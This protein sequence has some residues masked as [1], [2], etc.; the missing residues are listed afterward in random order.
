MD[1]L[2]QELIDQIVDCCYLADPNAVKPCGLV[3][4]RW[5]HRSRYHLFS[6]VYLTPENLHLFLDLVDTSCHPILSFIRELQLDYLDTPLNGLNLPRLFECSNLTHI[7]LGISP[8]SQTVSSHEMLQTHLRS[9]SRNSISISSFRLLLDGADEAVPLH[10]IT[11]I[12]ACLASVSSLQIGA[13][14]SISEETGARPADPPSHLAHL[15]LSVESGGHLVLSWLGSAPGPP[16]LRTL[17]FSGKVPSQDDA[18]LKE[19]DFQRVGRTLET[20]E[21]KIRGDWAGQCA[22][23]L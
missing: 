22:S 14:C 7:V 6:T 15:N 18:K 9:W 3:C 12:I 20:L 23:N 13:F 19:L 8:R 1:R 2:A 16:S 4:R 21:L 17:K 11:N 5:L 10:K